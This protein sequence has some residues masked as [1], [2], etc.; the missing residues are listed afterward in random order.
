M[1]RPRA[2]EAGQLSERD[3]LAYVTNLKALLAQRDPDVAPSA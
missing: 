2:R 1:L 3:R